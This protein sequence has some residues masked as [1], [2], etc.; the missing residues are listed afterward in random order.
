V[1]HHGS[2][3]SST[4]AFVDAVAPDIAVIAAGYHNRFGHPRAEVLARYTG[5]GATL[6]RT[7]LQGAIH[8]ALDEAPVAS[9]GERERKPRYWYDLQ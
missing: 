2:R 4:L 7:D 8:V 9:I 6:S 1:P 3:T 5:I